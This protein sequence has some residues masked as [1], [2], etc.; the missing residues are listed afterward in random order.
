MLACTII[1]YYI[2]STF[3][4]ALAFAELREF[5][6]TQH[7][8]WLACGDA[9]TSTCVIYFLMNMHMELPTDI[10]FMQS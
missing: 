9:F 5:T 7:I 3:I 2:V 8:M 4:Q 1:L 10:L 6:T